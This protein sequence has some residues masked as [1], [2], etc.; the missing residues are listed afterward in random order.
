MSNSIG[1][2]KGFWPL[3]VI[4]LVLSTAACS[5]GEA[6][7]QEVPAEETADQEVPEAEA[8]LVA[9]L[10]EAERTDRLVFLHTGADW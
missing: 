10:A 7:T 9:A 1:T 5:G 2:L 6:N 8:V 4:P 3:L